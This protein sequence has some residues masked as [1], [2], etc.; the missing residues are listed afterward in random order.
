MLTSMGVPFGAPPGAARFGAAL[1]FPHPAAPCFPPAHAFPGPPAFQPAPPSAPPRRDREAQA[2]RL[3]PGLGGGGRSAGGGP[4][5]TA[6][7]SEG[8]SDASWHAAANR[9]NGGVPLPRR[10]SRASRT[11]RGCWG[12]RTGGGF[13]LQGKKVGGG[14]DGGSAAE[15]CRAGETCRPGAAWLLGGAGVASAAES[16]SA[17]QA[18]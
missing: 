9:P 10:R 16:S 5:P 18:L 14:G 17:P 7:L 13:P 8:G 3:T 6:A 15:G 11:Q 1:P 4:P 12:V 2:Q